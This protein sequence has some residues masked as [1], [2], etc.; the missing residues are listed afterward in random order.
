MSTPHAGQQESARADEG[1]SLFKK[2][3]FV[4]R[5][6]QYVNWC[7]PRNEIR[8]VRGPYRG[9]PL[10][11]IYRGLQGVDRYVVERGGLIHCPQDS[12]VRPGSLEDRA[13]NWNRCCVCAAFLYELLNALL[14][15][16]PEVQNIVWWEFTPKPRILFF[17]ADEEIISNNPRYTTHDV[18]ILYCR[19]GTFVIDP[20]GIQFG[21]RNWFSPGADYNKNI[22]F[23]RDQHHKERDPAAELAKLGHD[24]PTYFLMRLARDIGEDIVEEDRVKRKNWRGISAEIMALVQ[25]AL[26]MAAPPRYHDG[27]FPIPEYDC[28]ARQ[29]WE[30]VYERREQGA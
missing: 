27:Y 2:L 12:S 13:R 16:L 5:L 8:A 18:V 22:Y 4:P 30:G 24:S 6:W 10:P 3:E 28:W 29:F 7:Y 17:D 14:P 25:K 1:R 20:T 19:S 23:H 11:R 9:I 26:P 21:Y 15:L